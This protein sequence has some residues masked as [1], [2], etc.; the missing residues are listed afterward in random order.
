VEEQYDTA[1]NWLELHATKTPNHI[2]TDGLSDH[3]SLAP[4]KHQPAL[5]TPLY[6]ASARIVGEL[7]AILDRRSDANKY[8]QL[9]VDIQQ[10]YLGK[11]LNSTT[12]E[13]G[14]GTQAEQAFALYLNLVPAPQ[15]SAVTRF[16]V[17][18]LGDPQT[19][20]LSTGIFGTK[21]LLDVLS[22]EGHSDLAAAI[23]SQKTFPGWGYMLENG[24]TTLWEHW[25][26]SDNTF[27]HNHPMFG[28]VSQWFYQWLGGI[29]PAPDA[30]GF[31]RIIIRP[32]LPK[33]LDWVRCRYHSVRGPIVS[34]WQRKGGKLKMDVTIPP[35]TTATVYV[36]AKDAAAVTE[37][38][39]SAAKAD[40]VKFLRQEG[41]TAV[42]VIGSGEY[43]FHSTP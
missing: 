30:V 5:L 38:G 35:N 12:G 6:A 4:V 3:E 40:G 21:F 8:Q 26:G 1:K 18:E 27:S 22:R 34:D 7:A 42:F 39:V 11:F 17:N 9:S 10:A 33:N 15:R 2:L 32:Q 19:A 23:V 28:S 36:P 29:Q 16:L 14:S 25:K 31:D 13:I 43:H 41:A 37:S 24:A 20:H